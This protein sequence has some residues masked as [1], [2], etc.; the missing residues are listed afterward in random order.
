[1]T[2]R[3]SYEAHTSADAIVQDRRF[4]ILEDF[5]CQ[6]AVSDS[7]LALVIVWVPPLCISLIGILFCCGSPH[8]GYSGHPSD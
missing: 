2:G 1:M 6:A 8:H 4:V 7:L 5:G 3:Q